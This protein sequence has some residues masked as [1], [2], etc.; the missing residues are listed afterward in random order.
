[1]TIAQPVEILRCM[2]CGFQI[3]GYP[4]QYLARRT[5]SCPMCR[6]EFPLSAE[7]RLRLTRLEAEGPAP[8][9]REARAPGPKRGPLT[10]DP[11]LPF[12]PQDWTQVPAG[13]GVY[14][15]ATREGGILAITATRTLRRTLHDLAADPSLP[16]RDLA[17]RLWVEATGEPA[18]RRSGLVAAFFAQTGVFPPYSRRHPRYPARLPAWCAPQAVRERLVAETLNVSS[19]GLL[20]S[21]EEPM[22]PGAGITVEIETPFGLVGGEGHIA[23]MGETSEVLRAGVALERLRTA[24]DQARWTRLIGRLG[25]QV[26]RV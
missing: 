26:A 21:L 16:L 8:E 19:A 6:A 15:L 24:T 14:A 12:P 22:A 4:A 10:L 20:L 17:T 23:W 13:P 18:Q 3:R 25:Q 9:R 2:S 11:W 1:M 5:V 7:D